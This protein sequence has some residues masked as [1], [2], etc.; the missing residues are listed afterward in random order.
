MEPAL[1]LAPRFMSDL[2]P[3]PAA[4]RDVPG[5]RVLFYEFMYVGL[6]GFGGALPFGQRMLVEQQRWLTEEE[7]NET[8]SLCQLLPGPNI[9]NVACI[10]GQRF[11]GLPGVLAAGGG[12]LGLPILLAI[13]AGILYGRYGQS[14]AV[15]RALHGVAAGAAGLVV[16][17]GIKMARALPLV[18][19]VW[20]FVILAFVG[21]ALTRLPLLAMLPV[22][23][24]LSVVWAWRGGTK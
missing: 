6:S 21:A 19:P 22:L 20:L 1:V 15:N 17:T 24:G 10:V 18:W 2:L 16:A 14:L 13:G 7:F 8:L 9:V 12:I 11:R 3:V 23:G 5:L 4:S